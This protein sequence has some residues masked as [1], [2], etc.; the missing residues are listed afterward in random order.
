MQYIKG[1]VMCVLNVM[2]L[3]Q[4]MQEYDAEALRDTLH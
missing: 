1:F 2:L 4:A 3:S